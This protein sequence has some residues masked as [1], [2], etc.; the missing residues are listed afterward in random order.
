MSVKIKRFMTDIFF[1]ENVVYKIGL[2]SAG[3]YLFNSVAS[4][5]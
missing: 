4:S 1:C 2:N 3:I 5:K